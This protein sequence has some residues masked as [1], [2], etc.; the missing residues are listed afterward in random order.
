M[1]DILPNIKVWFNLNLPD[2]PAAPV[3]AFIVGAVVFFLCVKAGL[4]SRIVPVSGAL[5][6][7]TK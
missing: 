4:Q 3:L 7:A 5:A 2:V 1:G 6:E